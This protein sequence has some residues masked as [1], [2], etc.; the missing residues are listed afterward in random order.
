MKSAVLIGLI[1]NYIMLT[2]IQLNE[3]SLYCH[4]AVSGLFADFLNIENRGPKFEWAN[5]SKIA[6][7]HCFFNIFTINPPAKKLDLFKEHAL[8]TGQQIAETL[9]KR[10][11][12]KY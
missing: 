9:L 12:I 5:F 10:A 1:K 2:A 8:K 7:D 3:I 4:I 6:G 11:G